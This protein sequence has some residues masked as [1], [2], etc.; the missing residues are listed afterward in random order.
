MINLLLYQIL[1]IKKHTKTINEKFE[2]PD[3]SYSVSD[4]EIYFE[5]I[6]KNHKK[7]TDNSPTKIYVNKGE[8]R[9]KFSIRKEYHLKPLMPKTMK[10]T[11]NTKSKITKTK[12]GENV[13]HLEISEV[14]LIN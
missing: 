8:N 11:R 13:P 3:G 12:T 9:I 4:I 2:L 7:V 10:L 6:I 14:V 5:Y 1:K